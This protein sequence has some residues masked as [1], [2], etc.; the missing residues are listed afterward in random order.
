VEIVFSQNA[1]IS[2]TDTAMTARNV[3]E[4][5]RGEDRLVDTFLTVPTTLTPGVL[6]HVG[7]IADPDDDFAED[8][9]FNNASKTGLRILIKTSG[10]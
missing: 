6:Y 1:I 5:A 4:V 2:T 10:C 3:I 9:E 7:V 8:D